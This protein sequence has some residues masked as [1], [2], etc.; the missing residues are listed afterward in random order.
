M[1]PGGLEKGAQPP[2]TFAVCIIDRAPNLN[3]FLHRR[4]ICCTAHSPGVHPKLRRVLME[5]KGRG[6]SAVCTG[7]SQKRTFR[8]CLQPPGARDSSVSG[9][10][11]SVIYR[12]SAPPVDL[13]R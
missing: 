10:V 4:V 11:R 8:G 13:V 1:G 9:G 5:E 6:G 7:F 12:E 3:S 2:P